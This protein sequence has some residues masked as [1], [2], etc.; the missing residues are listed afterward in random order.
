MHKSTYLNFY[1][2]KCAGKYETPKW[3]LTQL[4]IRVNY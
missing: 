1:D 3:N 4:D 2:Q